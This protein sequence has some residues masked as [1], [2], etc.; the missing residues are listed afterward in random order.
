M[1]A[2]DDFP[3][4]CARAVKDAVADDQNRDQSHKAKDDI[5]RF[6]YLPVRA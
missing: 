4:S 3:G 2:G 6:L 1:L 5:S